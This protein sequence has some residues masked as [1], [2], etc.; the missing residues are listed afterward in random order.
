MPKPTQQQ[1]RL[2]YQR[3]DS[4]DACCAHVIVELGDDPLGEQGMEFFDQEYGE[5]RWYR[6]EPEEIEREEVKRLLA[7]Q[8]GG[9]TNGYVQIDMAELRKGNRSRTAARAAG[10]AAIVPALGPPLSHV[11]T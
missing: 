4:K 8:R 10:A 9:P 5:V 2:R 11:T 3:V 7:Q 1:N 6:F